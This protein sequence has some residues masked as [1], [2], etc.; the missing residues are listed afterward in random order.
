[1]RTYSEKLL[2]MMKFCEPMAGHTTFRIGGPADIW[3][4]PVDL[5]SLAEILN[6]CRQDNI[7]VLAVGNG[8]NLLIKDKGVKACVI[9]FDAGAFKNINIE[10]N[11]VTAGSGL[12]L[13]KL[14]N[15]LSDKGLSGIEFLAGIPATVGGA[16]VT[17]AG[18]DKWISERVEEV[19]VMDLKGQ[20]SVLN[21]SDIAFRYRSSSLRKYIVLSAKFR[22]EK[23]DRDCIRDNIK[24]CF[25]EKLNKQELDKPSAGCVFKNPKGDSA[26]RLIDASGLKGRNVGGAFVSTK[27][28]NFIINSGKATCDDVLKLMDIVRD[29]VKKDHKV[30]LEPEIKV[31]G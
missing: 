15:I 24:K 28:A 18:G 1:M 8:S 7:Q 10:D 23:S 26:G 22:F 11:V 5:D 6:L 2:S 30:E 9:N 20:V 3:A 4:Q 17:N 12:C 25:S 31:I 29:S 19:T 13:S 14:L 21:K 27:H 16:L